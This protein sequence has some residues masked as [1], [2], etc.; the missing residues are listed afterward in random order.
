M[1]P[2]R[3]LRAC[4]AALVWIPLGLALAAM[5][6]PS[7]FPN[8]AL[9]QLQFQQSMRWNAEV[10]LSLR[11][12]MLQYDPYQSFPSWESSSVS[13]RAGA[14]EDLRFFRSIEVSF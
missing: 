12:Q 4:G 13:R 11:Q 3:G 1:K 6:P 7:C 5:G 10:N 14:A 8:P 2:R 9:Q